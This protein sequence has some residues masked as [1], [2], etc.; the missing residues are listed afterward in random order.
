MGQGGGP[1]CTG[2]VSSAAAPS[3]HNR[4]R[5]SFLLVLTIAEW[6]GLRGPLSRRGEGAA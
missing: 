3:P 4:V 5:A 2:G 6:T 1:A